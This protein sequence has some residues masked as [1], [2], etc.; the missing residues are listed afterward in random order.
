MSRKI[1]ID[2][3]VGEFV[4]IIEDVAWRLKKEDPSRTSFSRLI[5]GRIAVRRFLLLLSWKI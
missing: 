4:S 5:A 2:V 3:L 1:L